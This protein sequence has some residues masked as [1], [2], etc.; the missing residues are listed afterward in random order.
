MNTF[1]PPTID[2]KTEWKPLSKLEAREK[3]GL[4][5]KKMIFLLFL[6]MEKKITGRDINLFKI[7]LKNLS[8]KKFC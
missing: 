5:L 4:P 1:I 7:I 2:N 8:L 3:L 6:L